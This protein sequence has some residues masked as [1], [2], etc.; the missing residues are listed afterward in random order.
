MRRFRHALLSD[1]HPLGGAAVEQLARALADDVAALTTNRP[2][3]LARHAR[4][5][6]HDL[7]VV[8]SAAAARQC[9]IGDGPAVAVAR[10]VR[11]AAATRRCCVL[12]DGSFEAVH[13]LRAAEALCDATG[14]QVR[15]LD[16]IG[17]EVTASREQVRLKATV[18]AVDDGARCRPVL[19]DGTNTTALL[20]EVAGCDLLVLPARRGHVGSAEHHHLA[21]RLLADAPA[22]VVLVPAGA[23]LPPGPRER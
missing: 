1:L 2:R 3:A 18:A 7:V 5:R 17:A 22:P 20:R 13:A 11:P 10:A 21:E 9:L 8:P 12:F 4:D 6:G 19:L 16:P 15:V 23:P 14:T